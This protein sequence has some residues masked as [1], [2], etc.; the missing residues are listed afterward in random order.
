MLNKPVNSNAEWLELYANSLRSRRTVNFF[1]NTPVDSS[2]ILDAM[3]VARWAPNHRKTE[4]WYFHLLGSRVCGQ[5]KE[6]ITDIKAV[7]QAETARIAIRDRLDAIPGWL[8]M[9]CDVSTDP[10][11]QYEDYAA[12]ACAAQNMM[13]YLWQAGVGMKWTTGKVIRDERFFQLMGIDKT[14]RFVV[15]LFWYGY[16]EQIPQQTRKP[17]ENIM[18][19]TE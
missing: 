16:P 11:Q 17:L 7:G 6:L 18:E 8:V 15:G 12:C 1:K 3:E 9:T 14:R 13:L 19:I 5:V 2:L 4:P 10:V